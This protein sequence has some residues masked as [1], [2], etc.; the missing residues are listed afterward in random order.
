MLRTLA[1]ASCREVM[2]DFWFNHFNVFAGKGLDHLWISA[3]EE[4]AIRPYALRHRR[5]LLLAATARL[6][7]KPGDDL[8]SR[9]RAEQRAGQQGA[10]AGATSG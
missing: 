7:K 3:F 6:R 9:Q 8:L 10:G 4:Q 5:D 1:A 2:V